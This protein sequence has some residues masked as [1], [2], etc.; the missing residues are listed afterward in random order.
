MT[1]LPEAKDKANTIEEE[2]E[3]LEERDE[4][5]GTEKEEPDSPWS[6]RMKEVF[7]TF[8]PLGLIAFGG[9]QA[10][11]ALLRDHLVV[12]RDWMDEDAFMELFAIGQGLPGPTS[13][14]LIVSAAMS[15]AGPLG[16][17][18][19]FVM[20]SL[21][22]LIVL[23]TCGVLISSFVDPNDPPWYLIGLPPAAISLVFKAFYG[24]GK[25]LDNLGIAMACISTGISI[26]ING[27]EIIP[28]RSSQY[29]FPSM[30]V[31]GGLFTFIDSRRATPLTKYEKPKPGWDGTDDRTFK[32]IGIPLWVGGLIFVLWA[33]LLT[34]IV[35]LRRKLPYNPYLDIFE[36]MYRIGSLIFGGGQVVLPMLQDEVVPN[37][38]TESQF[39]QGL[40]LSQSMPGPLF[41]FSAYLGAV[42]YDVPGA[43]VG[44]IAIFAPGII[45]IYGMV[46]FWAK[47]RHYAWFKAV[48]HGLNSTAIGF[49]GAACIILWEA[50]VKTRADAIVFVFAGSLAAFWNIKA[51]IV[52]IL[53]GCLGGILHK[54]AASLGQVPFCVSSGF[55]EDL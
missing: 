30:L 32:R 18:L 43:I 26:L 44:Y 22:G 27:D 49:I 42:F 14:Q 28:T 7:V 13:T 4:E 21:P 45:L 34:I 48:L 33:S 41:N 5:N 8:W 37:W 16:G 11:V 9:P 36:V 54:D 2:F 52:V 15:R 24:F 17:I 19:A 51:P 1:T 47:M 46:P 12:Q 20:F 40:G 55:I 31:V 38:M 39:L 50:G 23:T 6:Q 10:T 53:G 25:K 35:L 3:S 29:V